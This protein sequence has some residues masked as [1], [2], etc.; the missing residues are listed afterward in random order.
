MVN[1][2]DVESVLFVNPLFIK[3]AIPVIRLM[4]IPT[5][6]D[7][8]VMIGKVKIRPELPPR[9]EHQRLVLKSYFVFIQEIGTFSLVAGSDPDSGIGFYHRLE[10]LPSG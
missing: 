3:T 8:Q 10:K 1:K 7:K 9:Q 5:N 6:F 4:I 2:K